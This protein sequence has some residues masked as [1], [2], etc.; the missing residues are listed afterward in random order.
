MNI[1]QL[2]YFDAVCTFGSVSDASEY[3]HISQPS[4]SLAIKELENEFG[5]ILFK[6]H[7]RGMSLTEEGLTLKKLAKDILAGVQYT[8]DVM[9][10][11]GTGRKKLRLGVPPMI[12]SLILPGIFKDFISA[13]PDISLEVVEG[14]SG[15]LIQKLNADCV[16]MIFLTHNKPPGNGILSMDVAKLEI[17]CC[18]HNQ[19]PISKHVSISP[20]DLKD[21]PI[22]LLENSYFQ[23]EEVKKWFVSENVTPKVILQTKQLSTMM[24]VVSNNIAVGF[25]FRSLVDV[26]RGF[27]PIST[28]SPMFADVSLAWK[29]KTYPFNSMTCFRE[30][31]AFSDI[32]GF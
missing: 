27:V 19:N 17:V 10:D 3:L 7:H 5:V 32:F 25:M 11:L 28:Q 16:D 9:K 4:L 23:T 26:S 24:S 8:E 15:E 6:R 30:Y 29:N 14:G 18:A 2:K 21:T 12:A 13:N 31:I 22:V 20:Q 1:V